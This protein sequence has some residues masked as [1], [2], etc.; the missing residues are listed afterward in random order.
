MKDYL[1]ISIYVAVLL[2]ILTQVN[3]A[4]NSVKN[5]AAVFTLDFQEKQKCTRNGIAMQLLEIE[6]NATEWCN[7]AAWVG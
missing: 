2:L 4:I 6:I 5:E 7:Y 1:I 3:A